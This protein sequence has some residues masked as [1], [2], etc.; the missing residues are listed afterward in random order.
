MNRSHLWKFLLIAFL[1]VWS[2]SEITPFKSKNLIDQFDQ[3]ALTPDATFNDIVKR[4]RDLE[5]NNPTGYVPATY[6]NLLVAIGQADIQK[7]FPSNFVENAEGRSP[8]QV[9]L[10]RLQREAAGRFKLGLDLS[11]ARRGPW[12]WT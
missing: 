9:I 4:A 12:K 1:I 7:Y 11:G 10:N 8:Q 3:S 6:S 2:L 5:T